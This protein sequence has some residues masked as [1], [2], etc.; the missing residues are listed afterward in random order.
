MN[1]VEEI[2]DGELFRFRLFSASECRD[3]LRR[4]DAK[5]DLNSC[6]PNSMN[7]YGVHLDGELRPFLADLSRKHVQPFMKS[8][9]LRKYP[10]AFAIDYTMKTQRSLA[11]HVD[12]SDATLNVCLGNKF[13]GGSLICY[14]DHGPPVEVPQKPGY[15]VVH[16]GSLAHR[17]RP[18]TS[19]SRTNLVLWCRKLRTA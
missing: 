3:V 8:E 5:R 2:I 12:E 9:R 6:A 17:A 13:D 4:I 11:T 16:R 10:I 7:K 18:L 19:G 14:P 1:R 15:A